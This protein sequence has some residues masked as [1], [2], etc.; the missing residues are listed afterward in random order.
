MAGVKS[1]KEKGCCLSCKTNNIVD[2]NIEEINRLIKSRR[3]VFV[4]QFSEQKIEKKIIHQLLENANWAPSH[5]KTEPWRFFVF[6]G[7]GLKK[8]EIGRAHV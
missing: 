7:K 1:K 2:F 8:F 3:S 6:S 4:D 5:G